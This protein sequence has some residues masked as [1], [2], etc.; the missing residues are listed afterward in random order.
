MNDLI[1]Y[2]YFPFTQPESPETAIARSDTEIA[3]DLLKDISKKVLY[4]SLSKSA[5]E[6]GQTYLSCLMNVDALSLKE[7]SE[8]NAEVEMIKNT[9]MRRLVFG[10][11]ERGFRISIKLK[12]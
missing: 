1:P 10:E 3:A 8:L 5:S 9:G 12:K 7:S 2:S 4:S 11:E 6:I